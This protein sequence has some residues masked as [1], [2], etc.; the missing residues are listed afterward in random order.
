MHVTPAGTKTQKKIQHSLYIYDPH[1]CT[2]NTHTANLLPEFRDSARQVGG[3]SQTVVGKTVLR[4]PVVV[5]A[6]PRQLLPAKHH[7]WI[8][9]YSTK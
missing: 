7:L 9:H 6:L 2:S 3:I 1:S 5:T 8:K 4:V